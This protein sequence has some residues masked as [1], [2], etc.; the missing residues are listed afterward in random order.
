MTGRRFEQLTIAELA[1]V[2]RACRCD[3]QRLVEDVDH[4][5]F[6]VAAKHHGAAAK[7]MVAESD[8]EILRSAIRHLWQ[9]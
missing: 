7:L 1:A 5:T 3:E 9:S 2:L 4:A 8:L 6:L